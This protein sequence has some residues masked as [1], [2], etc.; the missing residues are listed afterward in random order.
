MHK[1]GGAYGRAPE[2]VAGLRA[3]APLLCRKLSVPTLAMALPQ[4]PNDPRPAAPR[5]DLLDSS[6]PLGLAAR[7]LSS[8]PSSNVGRAKSPDKRHSALLL[9]TR[10]MRLERRSR[11]IF[12]FF[13]C[14]PH[15]GHG[16]DAARG[17]ACNWSVAGVDSRL[18]SANGCR[19]WRDGDRRSINVFAICSTIRRDFRRTRGSGYAAAA[20]T[21]T[22]SID[23][24]DALG[25]PG[26]RLSRLFGS[27]DSSFL[28]SPWRISRQFA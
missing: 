11:P 16:H 17:A 14:S 21:T 27:P 13:V 15:E 6:R 7:R 3:A 20:A 26:R 8:R 10:P 19:T 18:P 24:R 23:R 1:T 9:G 4:R 25:K 22:P 28:D 5:L 2:T 12:D